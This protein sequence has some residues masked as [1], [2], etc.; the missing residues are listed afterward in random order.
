MRLTNFTDFSLRVLMYVG[1]KQGE[2]ATVD[3]IA[4]AFGISRNHLVKVVH[5]LGQAGYL[6]TVRGRSGG[7]RLGRDAAEIN[8]GAVIRETEDDLAIVPCFPGGGTPCRISPACVLKGV[9]NE[10]L[11]SFLAVLDRHTLAD[12]LAPQ[13]RL[14][15]LLAIPELC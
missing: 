9:L 7:L 12:L 13:R 6:E 10:A 8:L 5:R 1:T 3:E 4:N 14:A 11:S 2:L 15:R